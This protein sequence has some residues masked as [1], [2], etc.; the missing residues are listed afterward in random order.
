VKHI[1]RIY[2]KEVEIQVVEIPEKAQ[3]IDVGLTPSNLEV[4]QIVILCD[5]ISP[6]RNVPHYVH[7]VCDK[8]LRMDVED[9]LGQYIGTYQK[10]GNQY[11]LFLKKI[12]Q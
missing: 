2:L 6:G 10:G 4:P 9:Y 5:K 1:D 12:E 7:T 11:F 8:D 3:I